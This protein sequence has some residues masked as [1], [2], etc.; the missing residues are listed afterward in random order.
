MAILL[1]PSASVFAMAA[2][3][4]RGPLRAPVRLRM[5]KNFRNR[6]PGRN[7]GGIIA[8][9]V[10]RGAPPLAQS[11]FP[12]G[13]LAMSRG[14]GAARGAAGQGSPRRTCARGVA[15]SPALSI[16]VLV[17]SAVT[18]SVSITI[19]VTTILV[20]IALAVSVLLF[21]PV[22]VA[23]AIPL[24]VSITVLITVAYSTSVTAAVPSTG[25]MRVGLAA[26]TIGFPLVTPV[27]TAAV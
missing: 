2:V 8:D 25:S 1:G 15:F 20:P 19:S 17:V 21:L 27:T 11:F 5:G 24:S 16:P 4:A 26:V 22:S 12:A 23:P 13:S 14:F 7:F 18:I 9:L 6:R 10:V 3:F